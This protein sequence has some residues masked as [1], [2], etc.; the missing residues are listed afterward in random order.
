LGLLTPP[1]VPAGL[2]AR[3]VGAVLADRRRR[4]RRRFRLAG[5]LALAA[6]IAVVVLAGRLVPPPV[7]EKAPGG[8]DVAEGPSIRQ[9]VAGAGGGGGGGRWPGEG[10]GGAGGA[11]GGLTA[12]GGAGPGKM[13][14]VGDESLLPP[15]DLQPPLEPP[16]RSLLEAGQGIS[17]GLEPIADS[18]W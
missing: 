12:G 16:G 8:P 6:S 1:P 18:A 5:A 2:T 10:G 9:P 17:A 3:V 11:V 14:R 7:R 4:Q 13:L 15:M